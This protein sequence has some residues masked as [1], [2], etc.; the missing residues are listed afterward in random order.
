MALSVCVFWIIQSYC[1]PVW[2]VSSVH[3]VKHRGSMLK[4][5]DQTSHTF[6]WSLQLHVFLLNP[7]ILEFRSKNCCSNPFLHLTLPWSHFI[8]WHWHQFLFLKVFFVSS[9]RWTED[10]KAW[11]RCHLE[12]KGNCFDHLNS[13][14]A[15]MDF[16]RVAH[17]I[18][19]AD[20]VLW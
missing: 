6:L 13:N 19:K 17:L 4:H 3:P 8:S 2:V 16:T 5:S 15:T 11:G 20:K 18:H 10:S 1:D 14:I 7:S 12:D 9:F